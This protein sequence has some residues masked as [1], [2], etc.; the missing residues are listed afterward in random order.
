MLGGMMARELHKRG[1]YVD[2]RGEQYASPK[3]AWEAK[4]SK[5]SRRSKTF[6]EW[7]ALGYQVVKGQK[8]TSWTKDGKAKFDS[9]QVKVREDRFIYDYHEEDLWAHPDYYDAV[10]NIGDKD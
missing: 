5:V 7:K 8:A 10:E 4:M 6:D 1:L 9:K 3:K 2:G